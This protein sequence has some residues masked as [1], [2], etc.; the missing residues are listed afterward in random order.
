MPLL[1]LQTAV[2]RGT[3]RLDEG[4][5]SLDSRPDISL[6]YSPYNLVELGMVSVFKVLV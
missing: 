2:I 5:I 6:C 4:E 1:A 3:S